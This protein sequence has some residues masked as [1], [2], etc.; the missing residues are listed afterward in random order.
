M[1]PLQI[2]MAA[3]AHATTVWSPCIAT[4]KAMRRHKF[5]LK[6]SDIGGDVAD[7]VGGEILGSLVHDLVGSGI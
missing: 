2:A 6:A 1:P 7:L 3:I 4:S 5:G